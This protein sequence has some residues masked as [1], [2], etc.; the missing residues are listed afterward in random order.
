VTIDSLALSHA[1]AREEGRLMG[2]EQ[3]A[4]VFEPEDSY[5]DE[6][7]NRSAAIRALGKEDP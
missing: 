6:P 5:S 1:Q 4:K 7:G 2:L 3:A